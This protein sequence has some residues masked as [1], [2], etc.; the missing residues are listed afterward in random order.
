MGTQEIAA[1]THAACHVFGIDCS[2]VG[3]AAI[4]VLKTIVNSV[5]I[6]GEE[7]SGIVRAP[8]GYEICKAKMDRLSSSSNS[9]FS[10]EVVRD[11]NNK[12]L[13]YLMIVPRTPEGR[14]WLKAEVYLEFVPA[15]KLGTS[16]CWPTGVNPWL[17]KDSNCNFYPGASLP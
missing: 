5:G 4:E 14:Q 7:C 8:V 16:D 3:G 15:G 6:S 1:N 2:A 10:T 13:S 9:R 17:C 11:Q 12:G